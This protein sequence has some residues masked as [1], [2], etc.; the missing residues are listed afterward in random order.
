MFHVEQ[1]EDFLIFNDLRRFSTNIL[2]MLVVLLGVVSCKKAD[3]NPEL[4][5]SLSLT[6]LNELK[7]AEADLTAAK[8]AVADAEAELKK[9]VPQTGQIKY[10]LKRYWDARNKLT[11]AEQAIQGL[12]VRADM[13]MWQVRVSNL[14]AFH[15]GEEFSGAQDQESYLFQKKL[16]SQSR[17]WSVK[18]RR[19]QAGL[20]NERKP[21]SLPTPD[22]EPG[23]APAAPEKKK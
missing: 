20:S 21:A 11:R 17:G 7:S 14:E 10:G 15:K 2:A 3:P 16:D 8:T 6:I 4:K 23:A 13:R 19:T 1:S 12:K 18:Q 9:V 22:A 5:D